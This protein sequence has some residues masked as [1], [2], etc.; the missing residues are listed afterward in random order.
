MLMPLHVTLA[1]RD[2]DILLRACAEYG[3]DA[4]RSVV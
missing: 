3:S 2:V 4:R 1:L